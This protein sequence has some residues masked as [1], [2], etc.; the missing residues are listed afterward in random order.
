MTK[1]ELIQRISD[2]GTNLADI[3]IPEEFKKD[4]DIAL[5]IAKNNGYF[6]Q[7]VDES[8]IDKKIVL[9]ALKSNS[10]SVNFIPESF[11]DD[12]DVA[13]VIVS[14]D[15]HM[16]WKMSDELI[17]DIDVVREAVKNNP[18]AIKFASDRIKNDSTFM[19]EF[20]QIKQDVDQQ[21]REKDEERN[22]INMAKVE[23]YQS[24]GIWWD[25]PSIVNYEKLEEP[26]TDD[27]ISRIEKKYNKKLPK[28]YV[29]LLKEQNGGRLIKRYFVNDNNKIFVVDSI[30]GIPSVESAKSSLEYNT[31][32]LRED[33]NEWELTAVKSDDIIVLGNDESG[34]HANYIFDYSK[35]NEHGEPKISH[36]DN[37]LDQ[38]IVIANGFEDFISKLKIEEEVNF[39]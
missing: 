29:E 39:N 2:A 32:M 25:N 24:K 31:D 1:E 20:E 18:E 10:N 11:L 21:K 30:L 22:K 33:I 27:M 17:D 13:L 4:Y 3:E 35:L 7:K 5:A 38:N 34:G 6:I 19:K 16:L 12:K 8:I 36:F 23:E 37:E 26:I 9:E 14:N 15:G 28:K